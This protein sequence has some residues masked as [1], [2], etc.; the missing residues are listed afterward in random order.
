MQRHLGIIIRGQCEGRLAGSINIDA[1]AA[2]CT[3]ARRAVGLAQDDIAVVASRQTCLPGACDGEVF[4][5]ER[6]EG[7]VTA[8]E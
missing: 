4:I 8:G 2:S 1:A 5:V 3:A 7:F 6:V